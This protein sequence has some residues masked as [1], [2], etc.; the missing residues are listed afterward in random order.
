MRAQ[1]AVLR[2]TSG[3]RSGTGRP[4][5]GTDSRGDGTGG[6]GDGQSERQTDHRQT[7]DVRQMIRDRQLRRRVYR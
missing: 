6:S 1:L 2:G 5:D 3:A 7:A 4:G